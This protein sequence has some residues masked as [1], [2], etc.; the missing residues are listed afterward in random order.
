MN[1]QHNRSTNQTINAHVQKLNEIYF[2][3]KSFEQ[4]CVIPNALS[5]QDETS[6]NYSFIGLND[7]YFNS[8]CFSNAIFLFSETLPPKHHGQ[9]S[10]DKKGYQDAVLVSFT[11]T[12]PNITT[13]INN[14][15][16][17]HYPS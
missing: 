6:S 13:A 16:Q 8:R 2:Q 4:Q 1:S 14:G 7:A 3:K 5:N 15:E 17:I 12:P 10:F 11:A 9:V